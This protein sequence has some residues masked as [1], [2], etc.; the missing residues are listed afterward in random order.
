MTVGELLDRVE[1]EHRQDLENKGQKL[2]RRE[3][4]H[5]SQNQNN[6]NYSGNSRS[7]SSK[8]VVNV[9]ILITTLKS[10]AHLGTFLFVIPITAFEK[11]HQLI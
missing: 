6:N 8:H 4:E 7:H 5:P 3:W 11:D 10:I 1:A 2:K 9:V